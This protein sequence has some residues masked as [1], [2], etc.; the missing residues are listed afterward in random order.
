MRTLAKGHEVCAIAR[1]SRATD[2]PS[3]VSWI[4]QDLAESLDYSELPARVDAII[5]LAQSRFYKEFPERA[6]D[7]FNVNTWSTQHLLEYGRSAGIERFIFASSGGVYGFGDREFIETDPVNPTNFY[8]SSKCCAEM[9]IANYKDFFNTIVLRPFFV[10]GEG[11][12]PTMLISRLVR[13][14]LDAIEINVQGEGI[15]INPVYVADAAKAFEQAL[16]VAGNQIINIGG[17]EVLSLRQIGQ[18]IGQE[19]GREAVFKASGEGEPLGLVGSISKMKELLCAP[20]TLFREGLAR[21]CAELAGS[22][23]PAV[24]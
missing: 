24:P 12:D 10:Y 17:S 3:E 5:H 1:S 8:L 16:A 6:Q 7:I 23:T 2:T 22:N 20:E 4:A 15:R 18:T 14:V 13:S 9:I 19:L 21:V 11:Q